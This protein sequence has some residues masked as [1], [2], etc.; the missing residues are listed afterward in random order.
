M[1]HFILD[2]QDGV[3]AMKR[4]YKR[5]GFTVAQKAE[6]CHLMAVFDR[7]LDDVPDCAPSAPVEQI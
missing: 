4:K 7:R 5:I 2:S 3:I 6:L 1:Q